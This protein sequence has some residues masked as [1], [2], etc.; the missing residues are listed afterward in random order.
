MKWLPWRRHRPRSRP[1]ASMPD[2]VDVAEAVAARQRAEALLERD[3]R[4]GAEI[5]EVTAK[6]RREAVTNHF[7]QLIADT[8]HP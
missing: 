2:P 4:R 7:A 6:A 8:F 5:R 1:A 3:K